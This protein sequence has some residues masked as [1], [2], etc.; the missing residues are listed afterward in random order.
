MKAIVISD[1]KEK[2]LKHLDKVKDNIYYGFLT[3]IEAVELA[4]KGV[5][6]W[7]TEEKRQVTAPDKREDKEPFFSIWE[8]IKNV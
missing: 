7:D 2:I 5:F 6:V 8:V 3:T 1:K 4:G